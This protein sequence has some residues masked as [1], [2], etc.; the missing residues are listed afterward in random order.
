M[1]ALKQ[2]DW[3]KNLGILLGL[4]LILFMGCIPQNA[5]KEG[6]EVT[7]EQGKLPFWQ[8]LKKLPL[9]YDEKVGIRQS[10]EFDSYG[11]VTL[12][13]H[14]KD[15]L[16][17]YPLKKIITAMPHYYLPNGIMTS[18]LNPYPMIGLKK[19]QLPPGDT[20]HLYLIFRQKEKVSISKCEVSLPVDSIDYSFYYQIKQGE[21]QKKDSSAFCLFR[22]RKVAKGRFDLKV[23]TKDERQFWLDKPKVIKPKPSPKSLKQDF[24]SFLAKFPEIPLSVTY[25]PPQI[26]MKNIPPDSAQIINSTY[27]RRFV[28]RSLRVY[29][30]SEDTLTSFVKK[31]T[32][33]WLSGQYMG[34]LKHP[35][36][37][38]MAVVMVKLFDPNNYYTTKIHA[39]QLLCFFDRK[40]GEALG[41]DLITGYKNKKYFQDIQSRLHVVNNQLVVEKIALGEDFLCK[42]QRYQ[43]Y[44]EKYF[45]HQRLRKTWLETDA[46]LMKSKEKNIDGVAYQTDCH[47]KMGYCVDIPFRVFIYATRAG[48][49]IP[50]ESFVSKDQQSLLEI[51]KIQFQLEDSLGK[52]D[53]QTYFKSVLG[54]SRKLIRSH[55]YKNYCEFLEFRSDGIAL[56]EGHFFRKEQVIRMRLWFP[57]HQRLRY[58]KIVRQMIKSF[59]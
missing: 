21:E 23:I 27:M 30:G 45:K 26:T 49:G 3:M 33:L 10:R 5:K 53:Y 32:L 59:K 50:A 52:P 42:G 36:D 6:L 19:E 44:L 39:Y 55:L 54:S 46:L 4:S 28:R 22:L 15:T 48:K 56:W 58:D 43:V 25:D 16:R 51:R 17:I 29:E 20:L 1:V 31:D 40:T 13:N 47:P 41:Y 38:G 37:D 12:V 8:F 14:Y 24:D 9:T 18:S 11:E 34:R 7:W 35:Q 2:S 57:Q